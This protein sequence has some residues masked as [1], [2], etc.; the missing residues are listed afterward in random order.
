MVNLFL[1]PAA[2]AFRSF[3][4]S[5]QQVRVSDSQPGR[6]G[7]PLPVAC[8]VSRGSWLRFL[9]GAGCHPRCRIDEAEALFLFFQTGAA[10]FE[11]RGFG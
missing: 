6:A 8:Q 3:L 9:A 11:F 5:R 1:L 4:R 10:G 2:L 7:E